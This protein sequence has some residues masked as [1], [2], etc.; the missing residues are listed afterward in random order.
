MHISDPGCT[1]SY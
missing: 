1:T